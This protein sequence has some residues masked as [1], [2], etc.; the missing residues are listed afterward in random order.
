MKLKFNTIISSF[1]SN[2]I[3][4]YFDNDIYFISYLYLR[5]YVT[6]IIFI[7][8]FCIVNIQWKSVGAVDTIMF[9]DSNNTSIFPLRKWKKC[10][11]HQYFL[12]MFALLPSF[13]A[14]H[15]AKHLSSSKLLTNLK[16]VNS[17]YTR[18]YLVLNNA[19]IITFI[20]MRFKVQPCTLHR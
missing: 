9:H 10:C 15:V 12:I 13:C 1:K 6:L 4:N 2:S 19:E 20:E 14:C 17:I 7:F 8:H 16:T 18:L 11:W 3:S 5:S